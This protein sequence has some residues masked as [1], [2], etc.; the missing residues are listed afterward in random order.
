MINQP[1][2]TAAQNQYTRQE[3]AA[4]VDVDVE[5]N[6]EL[7]VDLPAL[8]ADFDDLK[9]LLTRLNPELEEKLTDLDRNFA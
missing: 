2:M 4:N 3:V 6:I 5:V 9:E 7:S 8:Q 1:H